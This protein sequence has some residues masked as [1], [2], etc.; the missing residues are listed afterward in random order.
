[1]AVE[2]LLPHNV[3]AEASVLGALLIDP[4]AIT[5]VAG[6]LDPDDFYHEAHRTI[7]QAALD[8]AEEHEPA[9]II[10]LCD[11][12]ARRGK[13]DE[14]GGTSYVSGLVSYV[15]TSLNI[16]NHARIVRRCATLRALIKAA[17]TIA[18]VAYSEADADAALE[19]AYKALDTV[20]LRR[21]VE[22]EVMT[23]GTALD[24]TLATLHER[25]YGDSAP[26]LRTGLAALDA[27]TGGF[28]PTELIYLVSRPK[29]GKSVLGET[30][31]R[32]VAEDCRQAGKGAVLVVTLEMSAEEWTQR[33]IANRASLDTFLLRTAFRRADGTVDDE[34]YAHMHAVADS[35]LRPLTRHLLIRDMPTGPRGLER[36]VTRVAAQYDG[37]PLVLVDYLSL[38]DAD[39]ESSG[40]RQSVY[41]RVTDLSRAMK[42]TAQACRTTVMCLAQFN[43]ANEARDNKRPLLS[44][45]RDSGATEQDGNW[46]LGLHRPAYYEPQRARDPVTRRLTRFGQFAELNVLAARN[47]VADVTIPLRFE[48]AYARFGDWPEMWPDFVSHPTGGDGN[49]GDVPTEQREK[50][51]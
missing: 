43:R 39:E 49:G 10:V 23:L 8:L 44:D 32:N 30:I 11:E 1:M 15:T 25:A 9:D 7:F 33:L 37:C 12:L 42:R 14:V 3:E 21:M 19:E 47:G 34:G 28:L 29:M 16:R 4:D 13:L 50:G 41:E 26:T 38:L 40:K 36:L 31:A 17:G 27:H 22:Q 5:Q 48:G 18:G 46:I 2:K 35:D 24:K 6:V 45:I 51:A 20:A